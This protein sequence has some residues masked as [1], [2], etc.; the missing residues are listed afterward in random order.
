MG[1][2]TLP[3]WTY[4][5]RSRIAI[6]EGCRAVMYRDSQG[7]PTIGIGF[8]LNRDDAQHALVLAGVPVAAVPGVCAG[9]IPLTTA[10]IDALFSYS[11][12]PI[13]SEARASLAP[14]T[15]DALTDARRFV[16][17]DLVYNLGYEG[18]LDFAATRSLINQA[19]Q[20]KTAGKLDTAHALFGIAATHL[21]NSTW[22]SQVGYRA[23]R[24]VAM[25]RNGVWVDPEGDGSV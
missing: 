21:T 18:W 23:M 12:A 13:L 6:S 11:F 9:T 3:D 24:D 7:I 2:T 15:F 1:L 22:Y 5:V 17:C 25:I 8:N 14:G 20:A 16:V 19:Q 4:E 10:Q